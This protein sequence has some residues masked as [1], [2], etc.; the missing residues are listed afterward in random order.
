MNIAITGHRPKHMPCK[1]DEDHPWAKEVK[2]NLQMFLLDFELDYPI[3]NFLLGMA[4]GW[5]TWVA[6]LALT[7]GY[8]V[9]AYI[10]AQN[11]TSRWPNKATERYEAILAHP[12]TTVKKFEGSYPGVLFQRNKAMMD[13]SDILL[14]LWNPDIKTGGTY[15]SVNYYQKTYPDKIIENFWI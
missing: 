1:Y 4:L 15:D 5:D 2:Q 10:P 14:A 8:G 11:Q 6:E 12:F 3:T 13:D 9:H 7:A